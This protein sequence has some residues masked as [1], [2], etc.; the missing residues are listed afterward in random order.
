MRAPNQNQART[1]RFGVFEVD[2]GSRELRKR[3]VRVKLQDQ[4]F[5]VL[6]ALLEKPGEIVTRE[7]LKERL[8]AQDE[9]VEF[10]KSLNTA[11]QK[12]RQA[13]GDSAST[14]RFVETIPKIGYRFT[15][16][17]QAQGLARPA[18][19]D[20]TD[21]KNLKRGGVLLAALAVASLAWWIAKPPEIGFA[22]HDYRLRRLT[23]DGGLAY[24]ADISSDGRFVVYASD[25]AGRGD[26]DIWLQQTSESQPIRLTADPGDEIEPSF[27]P[28]GSQV[29]YRSRLGGIF[30][31]SALGGEPRPLAPAG[32][33]P[34]FSPDGKRIAFWTG[35]PHTPGVPASRVYWVSVEGV[36]PHEVGFGRSP[37]WS[38]AGDRLLYL[39]THG[40]GTVLREWA[41]ADLEG[42]EPVVTEAVEALKEAGLSGDYSI[43]GS[44]VFVPDRW[45]SDGRVLFSSG[46][47]GS[48]S[49]WSIPI[50]PETGAVAG[51]PE[52]LT[53]ASAEH[54]FAA[55]SRDARLVLSDLRENRDIWL[56]P[57]D[58]ATGEVNGAAQRATS[59]GAADH[60]PA[61]SAD[62]MTLA[63]SSNR[64]GAPDVWTKD[65]ASGE[66]RQ[67]TDT[68]VSEGSILVRPDGAFV[69]YRVDYRTETAWASDTYAVRTADGSITKLCEHCGNV[70]DWSPSGAFLIGYARSGAAEAAGL[71]MAVTLTDLRNG[72]SRVIFENQ[73]DW[74]FSPDE[75]W[76]AF[77]DSSRGGVDIR[78]VFVAPFP[79]EGNIQANQLIPI[80]DGTDNSSIAAWSRDGRLI[81]YISDRDGS[82]C[83][84]AQPI[85][86]QT[87]RPEGPPR[88]IYHQHSGRLSMRPLRN[89]SQIGLSVARD[90]IALA[91][92]ETTSE[93]WIMEPSDAQ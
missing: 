43:I 47:R 79:R 40:E 85:H 88:G 38:P 86:P 17:V 49:L 16:S 15:T 59:N 26:L 24:Q 64:S 27:S 58:P 41:L 25:R 42:G 10:D 7:E 66:L 91:M 48:M 84:Y 52:R 28:D 72:Q 90:K 21:G 3:G 74:R 18:K 32:R 9:F 45:L 37:V 70:S 80:T 73:P 54:R 14:P 29:V 53:T 31:V 69:T 62:G 8:W 63:F 78:Q 36:E 81:Y 11:V 89:A 51:A 1:F 71:G 30:V 35:K 93:I 75:R 82:R 56:L 39:R 65:L 23:F 33:R 92:A 57:I 20:A 34:R 12:I 60:R 44:K 77:H 61:L 83:I 6:E 22:P 68:E 19:D 50:S 55:A 67:L 46:E 5:R 87:K 13:L 4:P 76:L 2:L